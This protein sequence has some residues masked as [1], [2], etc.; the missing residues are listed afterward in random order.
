MGLNTV[1]LKTEAFKLN[2]KEGQKV[3]AG[4]LLAEMNL[5]AVKAEGKETTIVVVMTNS[6]QLKSFEV[7]N[8]G[9][10]AAK[11]VIGQFES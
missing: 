9:I 2:V 1:E 8:K 10:Q 3:N 7:S 5:S 11:A 6:D 4:E